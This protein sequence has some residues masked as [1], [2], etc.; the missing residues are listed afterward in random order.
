MKVLQFR[1]GASYGIRRRPPLV[2]FAQFRVRAK[3][4]DDQRRLGMMRVA[5]TVALR[6]VRAALSAEPHLP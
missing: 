1:A 5:L 6:E 4:V 3:L 2:I